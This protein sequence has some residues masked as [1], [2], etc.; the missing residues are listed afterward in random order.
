MTSVSPLIV[1]KAPL[2]L[3]EIKKAKSILLH[4]HPSPDPDSVGSAL[5]MKFALEQLGKKATVI[6]G[7]S[8]IPQ[9]FMHFPGAGD[10]VPKNFFE[11]DLKGFDLFIAQDSGGISMI[12]K[13]GEVI[14]PPSMTTVVIDHHETNS[15]YGSINLVVPRYPATGQ[16]LADLFA[17][18]GIVIDE[19]IAINLFV[20]IYSDTGGLRYAGVTS[21][22]YEIMAKLVSHISD[23]S[24]IIRKM[25][26]NT[27]G[28]MRFQSEALKN[29]EVIGEKFVFSCV[30]HSFISENKLNEDEISAASIASFLLTVPQ[31]MASCCLVEFEPNKVKISFRSSDENTLD[32]SIIAKALGGGGHRAAAAARLDSSLEEAKQAVVAKVKEL[33][34]L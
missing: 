21:H 26:S 17:E 31:F 14:F 18:W 34:K 29:I 28:S 13:K 2:I 27:L 33:Y 9:A 4:C 3:A 7:D 22:T 5:A 16:V 20:G 19:N 32:V 23:F 8:A 6:S 1:E 10:I 15:G 30:S 12:S 25:H 24:G 11:V